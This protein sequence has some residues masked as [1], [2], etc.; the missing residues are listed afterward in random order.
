METAKC[1]L[2]AIASGTGTGTVCAEQPGHLCRKSE[3][4]IGIDKNEAAA[5]KFGGTCGK[6][7]ALLNRNA[8]QRPVHQHLALLKQGLS[9]QGRRRW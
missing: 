9:D 1:N 2:A 8:G 3:V 7:A 6:D 4:V 5:A